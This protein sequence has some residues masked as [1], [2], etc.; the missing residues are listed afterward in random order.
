RHSPALPVEIADRALPGSA[1]VFRRLAVPAE[2]LAIAL[3]D[4]E[5]EVVQLPHLEFGGRVLLDC[6]LPNKVDA[7]RGLDAA[8]IEHRAQRE[9][10]DGVAGRGLCARRIERARD[11]IVRDREEHRAD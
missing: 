9:L 4:A 11:I 7:L 8:V 1:P 5:S 2:R 6:G 3:R 10:R